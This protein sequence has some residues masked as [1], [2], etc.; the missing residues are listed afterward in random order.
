MNPRVPIAAPASARAEH[1]GALQAAIARVIESG[2]FINGPD[3]EAF[4]HEMARYLGVRACVGLGSGSDALVIGLR[5]LG[6][7]AGDAVVVPAFTFS[8]SA[9]AVSRVGAE[10]VF[11]DVDPRTFNLD[12]RL[13][14]AALTPATKAIIVVHLYGQAAPMDEIGAI[15]ARR[16]VKVLEDAAQALGGA[17][18]A[19]RLGSFGDAAAFSFFPTKNL[20]ALGDAGLLATNDG[21][22][23]RIGRAL[24]Q[25]GAERKYE[26]ERIGYNSRLDTIQAAVLRVRLPH[27]DEDVERRRQAASRYDALLD[28]V[29]GLQL[30]WRDPRAYHAF[31]QYTVRLQASRREHVQ[32]LLA[33]RSIQTAV[34]YP[35][36]LHRMPVY[37]QRWGKAQL[38]E[39]ELASQCVLSLPLWPSI[40]ADDQRDVA[41]A[42]REA[43][44]A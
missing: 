15:A 3:V 4:E 10:P 13:L 9:E 18:L 8:A 28:D 27:L 1:A 31:N 16:G 11:V 33:T 40:D 24:R 2:A 26:S 42:L 19:Q 44:D 29:S 34:Y 21:D 20:G 39:A 23:A 30:P 43:L 36:P 5:A 14:E 7:G 17:Y 41:N 35:V 38:T 37:R 25:H 32:A 12:V 22:V 6:V